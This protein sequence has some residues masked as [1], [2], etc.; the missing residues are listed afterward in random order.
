[1][2]ALPE[3]GLAGQAQAVA[4]R[5]SIVARLHVHES[6]GST[7][8][9]AAAL[10]RAGA[11]HGT[12]VL[13]ERQTAGRGR[14]GRRWESPPGVGLWMSWVLR[15][16]LGLDRAFLVTALGAVAVAET[17]EQVC[18]RRAHLRWPNDVLVGGRKMAGLLA[19]AAGSARRLDWVV[20]GIGLNVNQKAADFPPE[21]ASEATSLALVAGRPVDRAAVLGVFLEAFAR[22]EGRLA[23]DGGAALLAEWRERTPLAGRRVTV[24]LPDGTLIG[25]VVELA[26][27][28]ALVVRDDSGARRA[29]YAADVRLL[30]EAGE[31]PA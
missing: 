21:F 13:A 31:E 24:N 17:V 11:P 9:E 25:T 19:E 20:L 23:A 14:L 27:D 3:A 18:G 16:P 4:L 30:R 1:M 22:H 7:N 29:L 28:G 8:D 12:L 5:A 15:P 10:A 26:D 2:S 6:V